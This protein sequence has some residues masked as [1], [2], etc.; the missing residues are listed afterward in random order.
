MGGLLGRHQTAQAV[1]LGCFLKISRFIDKNRFFVKTQYVVLFVY[2][3]RD[4][5]WLRCEIL[6]SFSFRIVRYLIRK[7]EKK[8]FA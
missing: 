2:F 7:L 5:L 1:F 8:Q 3:T 4:L 6:S